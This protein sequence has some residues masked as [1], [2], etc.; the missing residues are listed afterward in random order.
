MG[1]KTGTEARP[2]WKGGQ[3][4]NQRNVRVLKDKSDTVLGLALLEYLGPFYF[5]S[6]ALKAQRAGIIVMTIKKATS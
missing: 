2:Q 1:L 3:T 6:H 4:G 5:V